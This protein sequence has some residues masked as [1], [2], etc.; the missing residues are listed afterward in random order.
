LHLTVA[1]LAFNTT[2]FCIFP[3]E[4]FESPPYQDNFD[5]QQLDRPNIT[6]ILQE[7]G[8][9]P[10][11]TPMFHRLFAMAAQLT[12][13]QLLQDLINTIAQQTTAFSQ[14]GNT[15]QAQVQAGP[16][17]ANVS[18]SQDS[19]NIFHRPNAFKGT[20]GSEVRTFLAQFVPWA[21]SQGTKL[22]NADGSKDHAKWIKAALSTMTDI[23][24]VWATPHLEK[25]PVEPFQ[26]TAGQ[27]S[28]DSFV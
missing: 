24:A 8:L 21:G 16:L 23:A 11:L 18:V 19:A 13:E 20:V 26:N 1:A 12:T 4:R 6:K 2:D 17:V 27:P 22:N 25:Y 3:F 5:I 10:D 15:I 28:W 14:L 7:N 9:F